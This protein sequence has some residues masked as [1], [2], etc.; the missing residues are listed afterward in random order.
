MLLQK[1]FPF[2][3]VLS[4]EGSAPFK[5][6]FLFLLN[7]ALSGVLFGESVELV[8]RETW[9]VAHVGF[10]AY[11]VCEKCEW[12]KWYLELKLEL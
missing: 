5:G 3:N 10:P 9:V 1:C 6:M 11:K 12:R 2:L 4:S 7:G 8:V